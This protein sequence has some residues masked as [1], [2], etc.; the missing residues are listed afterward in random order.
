MFP[1]REPQ[2]PVWKLQHLF[3]KRDQMVGM[4]PLEEMQFLLQDLQR[5]LPLEERA[6]CMH[7]GVADVKQNSGRMPSSVMSVGMPHPQRRLVQIW[8]NV[9]GWVQRWLV[10]RDLVTGMMVSCIPLMLLGFQPPVAAHP[11]Q[12]GKSLD[13]L[14]IRHKG[15]LRHSGPLHGLRKFLLSRGLGSTKLHQ[16]GPMWLKLE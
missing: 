8:S 16:I 4:L 3:P 14:I 9:A 15:T 13:V 12:I 2:L 10:R 1:K 11:Q 7:S 5:V 6:T